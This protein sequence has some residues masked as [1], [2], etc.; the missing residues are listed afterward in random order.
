MLNKTFEI[1]IENGTIIYTNTYSVKGVVYV[2][3]LIKYRKELYLTTLTRMGG[4]LKCISI[5]NKE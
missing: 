4:R 1:L 3:H 2:D 5:I